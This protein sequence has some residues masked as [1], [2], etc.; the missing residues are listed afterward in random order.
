MIKAYNRMSHTIAVVLQ[1]AM[2]ERAR[3]YDELVSISGLSKAS[4]ARWMK[5][6]HSAGAVH[7][8]GWTTDVRGRLFVARWGWGVG[9]DC[10]RPGHQRT[11][12]QRMKALRDARK[13]QV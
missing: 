4:I 5:E 12:A 11:A 1:S 6:L 10:P 13:G 3:T 7:I 9:R 8:S 2:S